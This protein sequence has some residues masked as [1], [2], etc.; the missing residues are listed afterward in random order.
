[1]HGP[2]HRH[3]LAKAP[4]CARQPS[5]ATWHGT[6]L[7]DDYAW[8]KAS[9][10]QDVMRDPSALDPAI[11]AYLEAENAF[12]DAQLSDTRRLQDDLFLEM[13]GRLKENDSSVPSPDGPFA[14]SS[15]FVAGGQ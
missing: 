1:M 4:A 14:Y 9:N 12:C 6:E 13:K 11:R 2:A 7:V 5:A 8:L 3:A 10:W 15:S